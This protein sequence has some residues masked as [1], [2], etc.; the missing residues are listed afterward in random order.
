MKKIIIRYCSILLAMTILA[1]LFSIN[2]HATDNKIKSKSE[3][4][5]TLS[6]GESGG[7]LAG[8][9]KTTKQL[10]ADR[11][12]SLPTG[13]GFAAENANNLYDSFHGKKAKVIG[14]NNVRNGADRI[15]F[16]KNGTTTLIQD[17][18][19]STAKRSVNAAFDT[20][21]IYRYID[22]DGNPMQLEVPADQYKESVSLMREKIK[23][24]KVNNVTDTKEVENIV[25]KG[26]LTYKQA[27]NIT[28]AGNI[29]SL[30]YDAKT[31]VV[32]TACAAGISFVLNFAIATINGDKI[33]KALM[34]SL[35]EGIKTGAIIEITHIVVSQLSKTKISNVYVP[36]GKALS[37]V[38]GKDLCK[39]ILKSTGQSVAGKNILSQASKFLA[40][41]VHVQL[42][43]LVILSVPDIIDLFK[44]RISP[45]QMIANITVTASGLA[46]ATAGAIGGAA[47]GTAINPGVGSTVG[48]IVGGILGGSGTSI[49]AKLLIDNFTESDAEKMCKIIQD[50]FQK[51]SKDYIVSKNEADKIVDMV[52][53]KLDGETIKDMFESKDRHKFANNMLKKIFEKQVAKRK[54]TIPSD[55]DLREMAK[56]QLNHVVF[57]H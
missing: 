17:K 9:L 48:G 16:N 30:K 33:D 50:E 32:S 10:Y 21:G 18:Y 41:E 40:N 51:L 28:K 42:V 1:G 43:L 56:Q 45:E 35:K 31:G 37:K 53:E 7:Y 25:R 39:I 22:S 46:G 49:G 19:Y 24:G 34:D 11:K 4:S 5:H 15:I 54:I 47:I 23:A 12:F 6:L 14:D 3:D 44:G 57:V 38:L 36:A 26:K 55:Y 27:R 20:E 52:Q 13:H 29:D 8:S 2:T